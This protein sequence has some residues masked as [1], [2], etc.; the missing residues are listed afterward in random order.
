VNTFTGF[1]GTLW[2]LLLW[3]GI[4]LTNGVSGQ[5]VAGYPNS[6]QMIYYIWVPFL[7]CVALLIFAVVLNRGRR[8]PAPLLAVSFCAL[9]F[10][11]P[12]LFV[13]TG[14]I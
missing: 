4:D 1:V 13:Y 2:A 12:Y 3:M 6:G 11:F 5:H 9:M 14:G 8:T 7:V 10:L